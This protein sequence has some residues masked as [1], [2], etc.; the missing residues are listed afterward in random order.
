MADQQQSQPQQGPQLAGFLAEIVDINTEAK[1]GISGEIYSVSCRILEGNDKGRIIRRNVLGPI[2]IG[3][4]VRLPDTSRE[5]RE[6]KV[7]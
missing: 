6:I 2:K 4:I 1:T 5:A 7:K 3:D